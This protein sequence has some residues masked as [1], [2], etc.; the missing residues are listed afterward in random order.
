MSRGTQAVV[1]VFLGG[2]ILRASVTDLYL[3]YVKQ[4]L[5]PFLIAAGVVLVVA[6]VVALVQE[7]RYLNRPEAEPDDDGHGHGR[8]GPMV[9]WLLLLPAI[10]LLFVVPPAL[11]ADTASRA[12]S[13]LT[14]NR[15][16]AYPPLPPGDPADLT[17]LDYGY[18]AVYDKGRTL[19]G[20]RIKLTGFLATGPDGQPMLVRIVLSCCAADGVPIKIGLRGDVPGVPDNT[21]MRAIGRWIPHTA[22]DPVNDADVPYFQVEDWQKITAPVE[23]YE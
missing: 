18:R 6:A 11:G 20:R 16:V 7:L 5:R 2:A 15:D 22:K 4:G 3:R 12:G 13:A 1:L 14:D 9:G 17:L 19:S 23:P 21:W 10:A 8:S